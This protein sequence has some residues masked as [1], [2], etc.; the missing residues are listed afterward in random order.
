MCARSRICA[1]PFRHLHATR[2]PVRRI[3]RN[4]VGFR[5]DASGRNAQAFRIDPRGTIEPMLCRFEARRA[6]DARALVGLFCAIPH[7]RNS[8]NVR[9]GMPAMALGTLSTSSLRI[10]SRDPVAELLSRQPAATALLREFY[11]DPAIFARD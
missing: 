9:H 2:N 7:W 1:Q 10:E 8:S 11:A 4:L 6:R 3:S 5:F